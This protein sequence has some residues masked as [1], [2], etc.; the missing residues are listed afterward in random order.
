MTTHEQDPWSPEA[1]LAA[2]ARPLGN[3]PAHIMVTEISVGNRALNVFR[4]HGIKTVADLM[5]YEASDLTDLRGFGPECLTQTINA[6][7]EVGFEL[8][9]IDYAARR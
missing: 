9:P 2:S 5:T 6:L 4:R 7:R 8:K 1:I 3:N